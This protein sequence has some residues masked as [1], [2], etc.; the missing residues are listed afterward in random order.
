MPNR[1]LKLSERVR[2]SVRQFIVDVIKPPAPAAPAS[3]SGPPCPKCKANL[4]APFQFDDYAYYRCKCGSAS[5][6]T[7]DLQFV[8]GD[9]DT[10][11]S[12]D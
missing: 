12:D 7:L 2:Q 5:V 3:E 8:A 1:F 10:L 9:L 6:W 4:G 11:P